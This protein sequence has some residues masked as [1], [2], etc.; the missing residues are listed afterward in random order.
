MLWIPGYVR[1]FALSKRTSILELATHGRLS[2]VLQISD[3]HLPSSAPDASICG[4]SSL[5]SSPRPAPCASQGAQP[6]RPLL[7][8][9]PS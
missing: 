4:L 7:L 2:R 6:W 1:D 9:A 3:N 5:K 8:P